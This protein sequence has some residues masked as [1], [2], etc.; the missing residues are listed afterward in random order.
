MLRSAENIIPV[1]ASG[2]Y[3]ELQLNCSSPFPLALVS[4]TWEG[5]YNN[6]GIKAL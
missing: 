5:T 3:V 6:K 1:M 2:K 4:L